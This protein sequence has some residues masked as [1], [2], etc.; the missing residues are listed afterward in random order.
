M[1][2]ESDPFTSSKPATGARPYAGPAGTEPVDD[3]DVADEPSRFAAAFWLEPRTV[4][5]DESVADASKFRS[6]GW[7]KVQAD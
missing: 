4:D 1:K 7:L 3:V 2:N 6:P 5:D